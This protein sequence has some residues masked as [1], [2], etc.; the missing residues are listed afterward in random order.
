MMI[1]R[2]LPYS[3]FLPLLKRKW[4]VG[5]HIGVIGPTGSGKSWLIADVLSL[6]KHVVVVA[7][8]SRDATLD[9]RYEDFKPKKTWPPDYGETK[10]L[11]WKKPKRLGDFGEQQS[12]IYELMSDVFKRGGYTIAF[13]DLY[14]VSETLKLKRPLQ[15]LYTQIRSQNASIVANMQR[16]AWIPLE[17]LSQATFLL[18]FRLHDKADIDRVADGM[19][20]AR[21][22][23]KQAINQLQKY[24]FLFLEIGEQPLKIEKQKDT[25]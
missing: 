23:L 18:V 21:T 20:V 12:A 6:R 11:F 7:T 10:T 15:M 5:Q 25:Q 3:D 19:G 2:T 9:K 16:P 17:A 13:D 8:K 24:E 4:K 1:V 14:Y 22:E